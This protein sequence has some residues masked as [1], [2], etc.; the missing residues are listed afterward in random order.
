MGFDFTPA[1]A[2]YDKFATTIW[3]HSIAAPCKNGQ[4][5]FEIFYSVYR[6]NY[7]A[8]TILSFT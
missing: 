8:A 3:A 6:N 7:F 2:M 1:C 5:I 4:T